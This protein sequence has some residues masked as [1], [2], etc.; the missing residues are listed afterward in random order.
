MYFLHIGDSVA[1]MGLSLSL[2]AVKPASVA[3]I[4]VDEQ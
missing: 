4:I 2:V 3:V 1:T